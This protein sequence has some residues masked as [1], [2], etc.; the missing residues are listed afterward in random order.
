M[1]ALKRERLQVAVG[2][3][4]T[5]LALAP[6]GIAQAPSAKQDTPMHWVGEKPW[7]TPLLT[8]AVKLTLPS[9]IRKTFASAP[10]IDAAEARLQ[11]AQRALGV[12]RSAFWPS[13]S[14]SAAWRKAR[15]ETAGTFPDVY[16]AGIGVNWKLFDGFQ[17]K[18][19]TLRAA[20]E[21]D[22]A[23]LAADEVRRL[24]Q[25]AVTRAYFGALLAQ[26]RMLAARGDIAFNEMMLEFVTKRYRTGTGNRSDVLNF[27]IRVTEDVD[28][29]L[30]QRQLFAV[31]LAAL[32][33]LMDTRPPLSVNTHRLVNPHPNPLNTIVVNLSQELEYAHSARPDLRALISQIAAARADINAERGRRLPS[34]SLNANQSVQRQHD[35]D[36]QI[37][38]ETSS[39]VGISLNWDLFTGGNIHHAV[40]E[41]KATLHEAEAKYW[42]KRR[43]V[44]RELKQYEQTLEH[45][46]MKLINGRLGCEAAMEDR[47]M[48]TKLYESGLVAVTRLNEVQKDVAH[49][50]ERLA[51]ARVLF[52]QTW[53][54]LRIAAGRRRPETLPGSTPPD[55]KDHEANT[56]I[57]PGGTRPIPLHVAP[58]EESE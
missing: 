53:E 13:V 24:L 32:E 2:I 55:R 35:A 31:S 3:G 48:V 21:R 41:A 7:Q 36:V 6:H 51:Q 22:V 29:Y 18:F 4:A 28:T 58:G 16:S 47:D 25:R 50:L 34:I 33:A 12:E 27:K 38:E 19:K 57:D 15:T 44:A 20:L 43:E 26:E 1:Q 46:R 45:A 42:I 37:S 54:E 49:S 40:G 17:R 10:D 23:S 14:F 8:N 39:F 9:A 30:T 52:S 11:A 56:Y 5:L